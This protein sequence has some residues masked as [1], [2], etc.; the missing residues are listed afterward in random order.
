M[1]RMQL[2]HRMAG[3]EL[4]DMKAHAEPKQ[5]NNRSRVPQT[6]P[7]MFTRLFLVTGIILG[8]LALASMIG[9]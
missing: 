4:P 8:G 3:A 1:L 7:F 9:T 2:P 6:D 5:A